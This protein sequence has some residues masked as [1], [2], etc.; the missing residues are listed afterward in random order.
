MRDA[1]KANE[2]VRPSTGSSILINF[3]LDSSGSMERIR[4]A[5][6]SGFNEFRRDQCLE[7]GNA[8]LTVTL[9]NTR[10]RTLCEAVPVREVPDLD[11]ESYEPHGCTALYDAIGHTIRIADD[12]VAVHKPDQVLFVVLT[13]GLENASREFDRRGVFAMIDGRRNVSG[14]EF[15][16]LGANQDSYA[17]GTRIGVAEGHTLDFVADRA[18]AAETMRRVSHNVRGYRR[19]GLAREE[20]WFEGEIER[21]GTIEFETWRTQSAGSGDGTE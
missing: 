1:L 8:L 6:I 21:I 20:A 3:L 17:A 7:D 2:G 19:R 14:Y 13:D 16:Y 9:F 15:V 4:E 11:L 5:A 10:L 18:E 12:L